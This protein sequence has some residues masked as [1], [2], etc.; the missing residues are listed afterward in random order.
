MIKP[1]YSIPLPVLLCLAKVHREH[2]LQFESQEQG[3]TFTPLGNCPKH[4]EYLNINDTTS[5]LKY[6]I[7]RLFIDRDLIM[8]FIVHFL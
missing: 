3:G 4:S 1:C 6:L 5:N 7:F 2:N 8:L